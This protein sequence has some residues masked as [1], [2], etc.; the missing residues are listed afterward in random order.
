VQIGGGTT[1]ESG[2]D[3]TTKETPSGAQSKADTAEGNAKKY[4]DQQINTLGD[5]AYE[6]AV[7]LAKLG[8]TIVEGGYLQTILINADRIDTGTLNAGNVT[9]SS[10]DGT[11]F[12]LQG[13][14][15][16]IDTNQFS[17][18]SAGNAEFGGNLNAAS[19]SFSDG[20]VDISSSGI[21]ISSGGL[22]V[23]N[24][25]GDVIIDGES[26]MFKIHQTGT[27]SVSAGG[28][29]S[30][31]HGLGYAPAFLF[32]IDFGGSRNFP[33]CIYLGGDIGYYGV[34]AETNST[35][36]VFFAEYIN[37]NI[38]YFILKEEAF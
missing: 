12:N 5:M 11:T 23:T 34:R 26:D 19:G 27:V 37:T 9:I 28:S 36:V 38:K 1:Y 2:Y 8:K 15:L 29:I 25:D 6:D 24:P 22:T 3:P 18:D 35:S 16:T 20:N 10:D 13:N 31:H 21:T 30:V 17:L 33:I 14:D 7:E 32:F 4:A